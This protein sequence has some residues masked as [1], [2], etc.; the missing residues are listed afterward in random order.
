MAS[1]GMKYSYQY[2][3]SQYT[4]S[5]TY[6]HYTPSQYSNSAY[7]STKYSPTA[8]HTASYYSPPAYTPAYKPTS[9]YTPLYSKPS[10]QSSSPR[11]TAPCTPAATL[12][13][14]RAVRF[15]ND[16]IFQDLIRHSELEQIGRFMRARKVRLDTLF[17]SGE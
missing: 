5:N 17:H 16:V 2:P 9:T 14:A 4:R 13:P 7:S 6:T 10:R 11:T 15:T 12:K 8:L 1:A 3:V